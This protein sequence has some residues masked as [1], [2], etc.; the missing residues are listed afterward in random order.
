MVVTVKQKV[1]IKRVY[2]TTLSAQPWCPP[3]VA[4]IGAHREWTATRGEDI[5]V[6]VVDTGIDYNHPDLKQQILEGKNFVDDGKDYYDLNGHGTHVAG[7]IAANGRLMGVAPQAKLL[8]ARVLNADGKGDPA[9]IARALEWI[10]AWR[11][12]QGERVSVINMSL[13]MSEDDPRLH[14][15]VNQLAKNGITMVA[16][17]GN[18]G[19]AN[20]LTPEYS[21]PAYWIE[22]LAVGAVSLARKA[23]DFTNTN[24]RIAVVAPGVETIST[25]PGGK[26][27][28]LSGTSMASPHIAGACALIHARHLKTFG[29]KPD[30]LWTYKYLKLNT[31][32]LGSFG[33]DELYGYGLFSFNPSGGTYLRLNAD[34]KKFY[35]NEQTGSL[36]HPCLIKK[37]VPYLSMPDIKQQLNIEYAWFS[38]GGKLEIW[39]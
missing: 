16:A 32:D 23:A 18:E 27:V 34:S 13:G 36:F 9:W 10:G 7:T 8:I 5:V 15:V 20:P 31:I 33:Y 2:K 1:K 22:V 38:N 39:D 3:G 17:A 35:N 37:G 24:D 11:G 25:Y 12:P 19:D 4:V 30:P 21:Y 6:A 28:L 29:S 26:Y 14:R